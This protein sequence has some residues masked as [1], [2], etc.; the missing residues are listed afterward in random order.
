MIKKLKPKSEFSRNVL[1]LMTGTTIAQAIPIAISPILT[2]VYTPEDFG[3]FA[4]FSSLVI[5]LSM[6]SSGRYDA[7]IMLPESDEDA[8]NILGIA[9]LISGLFSSSIFL[10]ILFFNSFLMAIPELKSIGVYLYFIPLMV[11]LISC[12]QILYNWMNRKKQ[13]KQLAVAKV[14][15]TSSTAFVNILLGLRSF[16]AFGLICGQILGQ[17]ISTI[18]MFFKGKK[19]IIW[20]KI[21]LKSIQLQFVKY[22]NF[23]KYDIPSAFLN[24]FSL[25]LPIFMLGF[26]F[27][28][29]VVGFFTLSRRIVGLPII[30]LS[31]SITTVF[32]QR[33]TSDYNKYGNCLSIYNK[34]LKSLIL[35]AILPSIILFLYA[36]E[37][38][39]FVFGRHWVQAGEYTQILIPMFFLRFIS[40]PLS[41]MFYIVHKQKINM[42]GQG[43]LL[44][45][46][47]LSLWSGYILHNV[48]I[49]LFLFSLTFSIFYLIYLYLSY[50][51]AKGII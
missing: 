19:F 50:K 29:T 23:P 17:L 22:I 37:I 45:F 31:S 6:V 26:L 7:A 38:F 1:T 21:N 42:I 35:I 32:K 24:T 9:L 40:S 49:A 36:P 28:P 51:F 10:I 12:Y 15:Q 18:Y 47:A 14:S 41:Y 25:Q 43:S 2:R 16:Q 3:V 4:I 33:A 20:Q 46:S 5:V 44:I 30:V 48:S 8:V 34:T 13:F 27:S 11:F 39:S